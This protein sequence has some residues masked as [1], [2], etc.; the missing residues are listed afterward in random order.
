MKENEEIPGLLDKVSQE[1]FSR[2]IVPL[3]H[4]SILYVTRTEIAN[5]IVD[6]SDIILSIL[7]KVEAT[8]LYTPLSILLSGKERTIDLNM[9]LDIFPPSPG[10]VMTSLIDKYAEQMP[11]DEAIEKAEEYIERTLT[12]QEFRFMRND[13]SRL[14]IS[15][16]FVNDDIL[17]RNGVAL[18]LISMGVFSP[19]TFKRKF[20]V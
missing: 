5:K 20:L 15:L 13:L 3:Y 17:I 9:V 16:A 19:E 7:K 2:V 12:P 11:I 6:N 10:I 4:E 1:Y 14:L 8:N 18:T